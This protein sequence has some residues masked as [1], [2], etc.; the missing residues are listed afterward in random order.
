MR[1]AGDK[2]GRKQQ[3]G[4]SEMVQE[5]EHRVAKHYAQGDL[6]RMILDAL[7]ASGKDLNRLTA[8][9]LSPADEFHTG[10]REATA[11]LAEQAGFA[12]G[13]HLLDVGC[14]IGGPSRFFA[15]ERGCRV[16]GIDLTEDYVRTAD[17][18]SRRVGLGGRLSYRLASAVALPF[19]EGTF[20]GA[21]MIHVGMNIEDKPALF[22]GVHRVLKRGGTFAIFDIMRAADGELAYP[23][24]WAAS[25]E[26]SFVESA[27]EYRRGLE[28]AGF[29][30]VRERDRSGFAGR[31]FAEVMARVARAGGPPPLGTHLLM[32]GNA[33]EK[34]A[35]VVVSLE[36][37]LIAPTE[38]V[39]RARQYPEHEAPPALRPGG[40]RMPILL[41][42]K[43]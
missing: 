37:G 2:R 42:S 13:E 19:A 43:T 29:E 18:L 21:Y 26:T 4:R 39:C 27:A 16:T 25:E 30:I 23:V 33:A 35:N 31:F 9:D 14:G 5:T 34:L 41:N 12:A 36:N 32:K 6:E 17:A 40:I 8:E 11:A 3:D 38:L 22:A 24:P 1:S 7:A 28:A 20:D 15:V 10:G